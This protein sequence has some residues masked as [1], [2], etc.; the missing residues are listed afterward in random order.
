[1][2]ENFFENFQQIEGH[3]IAVWNS[4]ISIPKIVKPAYMSGLG[5]LV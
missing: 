1:M 2:R 3:R 4:V 5:D